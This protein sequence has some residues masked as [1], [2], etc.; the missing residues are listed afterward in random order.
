[1]SCGDPVS[2]FGGGDELVAV[3][4]V[5][6]E[7][8]LGERV[9]EGVPVEVVGVTDTGEAAGTARGF[10]PSLYSVSHGGASTRWVAICR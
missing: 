8:V 2:G 4:A 7:D 6:V 3:V 9:A 5:S 1:M 10:A